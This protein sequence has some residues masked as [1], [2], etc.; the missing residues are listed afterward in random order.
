MTAKC[1]RASA[2]ITLAHS[3]APIGSFPSTR[4]VIAC[5]EMLM[6]RPSRYTA[7]RTVRRSRK[8]KLERGNRNPLYASFVLSDRGIANASREVAGIAVCF[9]RPTLRALVQSRQMRQ[10]DHGDVLL[11]KAALFPATWKAPL[12]SGSAQELQWIMAFLFMTQLTLP[13]GVVH[14]GLREG[15]YD[16]AGE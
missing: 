8:S 5:V 13:S 4:P 10:L 15:A 6:P 2:T 7:G 9:A 14:E 11:R 3:Y 16:Q 12:S 1:T